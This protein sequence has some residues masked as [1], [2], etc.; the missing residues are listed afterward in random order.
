M[1][2]K[3]KRPRNNVTLNIIPT[4]YTYWR[5][6][7][8]VVRNNGTV[9]LPLKPYDARTLSTWIKM[10]KQVFPDNRQP[11]TTKEMYEISLVVT[12]PRADRKKYRELTKQRN[13]LNGSLANLYSQSKKL[14]NESKRLDANIKTVNNE[15]YRVKKKMNMLLR[16]EFRPS[17][18]ASLRVSPVVSR[19]VSPV[20]RASPRRSHHASPV[21]NNVF[22]NLDELQ[23]IVEDQSN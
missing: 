13:K 18:S 1:P 16:D 7:P 3:S 19:R 17:R 8:N 14:H 5:R 10:G 12:V 11:I 22:I 20:R 4:E 2:S 21:S 23:H 15:L 9:K 6:R